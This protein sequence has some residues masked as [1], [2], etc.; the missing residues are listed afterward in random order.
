MKLEFLGVRNFFTKQDYHNNLLID[1]HIL[2]DCGHTAGRSLEDSSRSFAD[3]DT[4]FI[5]HTHADHIGGLEECAFFNK[6]VRAGAKPKLYLPSALIPELWESSL[7]GGLYDEVSDATGLEDYFD[8]HPVDDSFSESGIQFDLIPT[9]HIPG[10]FC[11][12]L[13]LNERVYYSGDT[14]FDRDMILANGSDAETI[15]HDVQFSPEGVHTPLD[16]LLTLPP[17]IRQKTWLMHYSDDY[18]AHRQRASDAG[19]RWAISHSPH[20]F[21]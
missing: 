18:E 8:V 5:S 19:F 12:G 10:K 21:E 7:K 15:F 14:Q 16:D 11:C 4:L 3:I 9:N 6:Y 1:D 2:V 17:E 13:Q 20:I